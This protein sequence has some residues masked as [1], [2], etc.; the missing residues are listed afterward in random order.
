M[1]DRIYIDRELPPY[2]A[3]LFDDSWEVAGPDM[4]KLPTC[5]GAIAGSSRWDAE[6]MDEAPDLKVISRSG[7]GFD[8]VDLDAAVQRGI[9]VCNTPDAPTISTAEHT[10]SLLMAATKFTASNVAR[11]RQ[12]R[13]DFYAAHEG[14]ELSGATIGVVGHGR[15]GSRVARMCAAMDMHVLV[16]DPYVEVTEHEQ[17]DFETILAE[18]RIITLH[19][20]L[21]DETRDLVNAD[22]ISRMK[23]GVVI[24]NAARGGSIDTQAL[25]DAL[26]SGKIYAAGLDVTAPEPLDPD[27]TLLHRDNVVV[28]PHI[29]S[30]TDKGRI[31]MYAGA[32]ANARTVLDGNRPDDV[33]N[34]HVYDVLEQS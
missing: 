26:D 5:L 7:I 4:A 31:R 2:L 6:R 10:M 3:E 20:P 13:Q 12:G 25:I 1:S 14:I 17:V 33:V 24:V 32:I 28:T 23:D 34:P 30:A 11:L 19:T 8:T 9:V 16:C 21:T 29:A 27:H 15:I 22:T 18:S